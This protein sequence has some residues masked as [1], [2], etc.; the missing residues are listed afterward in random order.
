MNTGRSVVYVTLSLLAV[1]IVLVMHGPAQAQ[2]ASGPWSMFHHDVCHTGQSPNP[3]PLAATEVQKWQGFD[4]LRTSPSLSADGEAIYFGMGFDFCSV[5][6]A[7]INSLT[8]IATN[9]TNCLLL[10]ADVSDS[11]PAVGED[12]TI[13][14]GDRDNSLNAYTSDP[15]T[16]KPTI[17][18]RYNHGHEGD[19]WTS[20]AI[21]P[22]SVPA[23]GTIYFAH[24]QSTDGA[25][26]FTALIDNGG[27][28]C[29]SFGKCAPSC[30]TPGAC[31]VKWKYKIG[32]FVRQS[33][34]TIDH[35][36]VIYFGDLNGFI[37]AF[38]DRGPCPAAN[39]LCNNANPPANT[40]GPVLLWKKQIGATPSIT[41]SP[42]IDSGSNTL[43]VGSTSGLTAFDIT[44]PG[45]PCP[46]PPVK[47][48]FP[49]LGRVDTTP[50]LGRDGT[51]YVP[52][53]NTGGQGRLYAV[54]PNGSQKWVFPAANAVPSYIPVSETSAQP[55]V[56]ADGTVYV[57][58]GTSVRALNPATGAQLWS[59][60][61]TNFIQSLPLIGPITPD[62]Q[63]VLY[64]PSR[65]HNL[66][67][68]S[69]TPS[70]TTSAT[71]CWA[72]GAPTGNRPPVAN[73]GPDQPA[74]NQPPVLVNQVVTF[75]GS[76]S[77]DPD[78]DPLTFTWA[79]GDGTGSNPCTTPPAPPSTCAKPTHAYTQTGVYTATL[80]VSDGQGGSDSDTV[81][82]TVTSSGGG[83]TGNFLD[84]FTRPDSTIL[85]GPTPTGPQWTEMAGDLVISNNQLNNNVRGDNIAILTALSGTAQS[86]AG[87]F[88]SLNNNSG[89]R[90][91]VVLRFQDPRNHYRLYRSVGGS[92]ELRISKFVNGAET[93]L[94]RV[95]VAPPAQGTIFH[96]V[97]SATTT[98]LTLTM[99]STT[100]SINDATFSSGP[101]GV[102]INPGGIQGP[103]VADDF[104]GSIGGTCP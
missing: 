80:T 43:Y 67:V 55:I 20:P 78:G 85:G 95:A 29:D 44:C 90:L 57:G 11:S 97:A 12:G 27:T 26:I 69:G 76:G 83:G 82:I 45:L 31:T 65:D 49:T 42:V 58:L 19:I 33:S 59:F 15:V 9:K 74:Q 79:F 64:V 68:I 52:A 102:L 41:A 40:V 24:D 75:D 62:G 84:S 48:T 2:L 47:W 100:I 98:T 46:V 66:Y 91:G 72:D 104:C 32:T 13:Y 101:V 30:E 4:K 103:H 6:T 34:P 70:G 60:P 73:A 94:K 36:G 17:R 88:A 87:N 22:A 7:T 61:T 1:G 38:E 53:F 77:H 99:G 37:Y 81:N 54:S 5:E 89:P 35:N 25:G 93:V 28:S 50:A 23:A 92:N 39:L 51:V 86:A 21:A 10:P 16:K 14:M 63:A 71:T 8:S 18:W 96:L 56:G 3:G